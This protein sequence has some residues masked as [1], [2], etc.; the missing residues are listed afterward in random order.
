M[1]NT[2][3]LGNKLLFRM[4]STNYLPH[5]SMT[6]DSISKSTNFDFTDKKYALLW[7]EFDLQG[8][9]GN[10]NYKVEFETAKIKVS[11]S[12]VD[13]IVIVSISALTIA[14]VVLVA[15]KKANRAKGN[16]QYFNNVM[17][18]LKH[19]KESHKK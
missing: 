11:Y 19:D 5:S 14:I 3:I 17:E 13:T 15:I 18:L 2:S 7:G 9:A 1:I 8:K 6:Q 12:Y 16:V 4:K 10:K